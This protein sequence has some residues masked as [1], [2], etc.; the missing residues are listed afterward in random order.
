MPVCICVVQTKRSL[1]TRMMEPQK[2]SFSGNKETSALA[3]NVMETGHT[4]DWQGTCVLGT[5]ASLKSRLFMESS[6]VQY[7]QQEKCSMNTEQG[8]LFHL[9]VYIVPWVSNI[10]Y[11]FNFVVV[12]S[13]H[14][15]GIL[16]IP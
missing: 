8:S 7:I 2:D 14:Y 9:R 6:Y 16:L 15:N 12:V 4:I 3:E 13:L 1:N 10:P 11:L 5:C